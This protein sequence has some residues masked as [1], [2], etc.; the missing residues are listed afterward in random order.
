MASGQIGDRTFDAMVGRPVRPA[1][2]VEV[3]DVPGEDGQATRDLGTKAPE[4]GIRTVK[5]LASAALAD[6]EIQSYQDLLAT[7]VTVYDA[8]AI[9]YDNVTVL[10]VRCDARTVIHDGAT[11][12]LVRAAWRVQMQPSA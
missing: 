12:Q 7:S 2:A 6:A 11:Q 1:A 4:A 10:D 8:T 5:F 9:Q 3:I